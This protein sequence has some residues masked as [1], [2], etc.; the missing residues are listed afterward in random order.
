MKVMKS[1]I[2][3]RKRY[4]AANFIGRISS[5]F[6]KINVAINPEIIKSITEKVKSMSTLN[7]NKYWK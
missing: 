2:E 6:L 1:K 4:T 3:T 7:L 5:G